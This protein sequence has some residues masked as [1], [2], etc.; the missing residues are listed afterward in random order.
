LDITNI[1]VL[2]F[3]LLISLVVHEAAHAV[4]ALLGGDRTAYIGGQVTLNP[5]PH[6]QREPFGTIV[7]PLLMLFYN[8]GFCMGYAHT[9]IDAGWASRYPKRAAIM[10]AAGPLSNFL[11]AALAFGVLK[12]LVATGVADPWNPRGSILLVAPR[13]PDGPIYAVALLASVFLLL[14]VILG[15]LNLLPWPPLDGSGIVQGLVPRPMEGFY[16]YIRS[17]PLLMIVGIVAVWT[18]IPELYRPVIRTVS[19]WL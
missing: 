14:N 8:G 15:I 4:T 7:L 17:Q 5:V 11:L 13:D 16:A 2:Y 1:L 12:I 10:S 9:P 6:M 19:D 3:V 18:V